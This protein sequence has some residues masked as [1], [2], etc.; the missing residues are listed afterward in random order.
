MSTG[1]VYRGKTLLIDSDQGYEICGH[2]CNICRYTAG[3]QDAK[4]W[5]TWAKTHYA[6]LARAKTRHT[7]AMYCVWRE[8]WP[9]CN[10]GLNSLFTRQ[11]ACTFY[12]M[13]N[14][15]WERVHQSANKKSTVRW[16]GG[17][18]NNSLM[19]VYGLCTLHISPLCTV[20]A[21]EMRNNRFGPH[22]RFLAV[23]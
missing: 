20:V 13:G 14:N 22:L 18:N 8:T 2:V 4:F 16:G 7:V 6:K 15:V 1:S 12:W 21:Y 10:T 19:L 11:H 3:L 5:L 9:K 23:M 17:G